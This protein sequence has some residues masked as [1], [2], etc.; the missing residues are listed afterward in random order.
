MNNNIN[1]FYEA[2][3]NN[4]LNGEQVAN[5]FI[6]YNGTQLLTDEFIQFV[7][8]EGYFIEG[9]EEEIEE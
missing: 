1:K 6:N 2:I 7:S 4:E 3:E 5:L 8:D 9:Y